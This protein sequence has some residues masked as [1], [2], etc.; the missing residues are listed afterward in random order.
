MRVLS[1]GC[2]M[3]ARC[4]GWATKLLGRLLARW[5]VHWSRQVGWRRVA[6]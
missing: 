5:L 6:S 3:A 2:E 1:Q 4:I